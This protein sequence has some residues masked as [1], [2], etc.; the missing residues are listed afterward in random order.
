[1]I[2]DLR[3]GPAGSRRPQIIHGAGIY[4]SP[5]GSRLAFDA[6]DVNSGQS[7][8][9]ISTVS[10]AEPATFPG[11]QTLDKQGGVV[12]WIDTTHLAVLLAR[13]E[14]AT[15]LTLSSLDM[16]TGTFRQI[17][18]ISTDSLG[19]PS[20]TF[21]PDGSEALL[22][23]SN[24]EGVTS[25]TSIVELINSSTGQKRRL[26]HINSVIQDG[27]QVIAWKPGTSQVLV[28]ADKP[29]LLDLARDT[30]TPFA[31]GVVPLGWAPDTG[32]LFT[33]T[34]TGTGGYQVNTMAAPP[35]ATAAQPVFSLSIATF[36]FI[37]FVRAG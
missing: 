15:S 13:G 4:W 20:F 30:A 26:P 14:P 17:A 10:S 31:A 28:L 12:G 11:S 16:T 2:I 3:P 5:D 33:S 7:S 19:N 18:P 22:T 9:E 1:M 35:P 37:G 23:N 24:G 6:Y 25:F 32:T 29:L 27:F 34:K 36:P 8:W 21:S